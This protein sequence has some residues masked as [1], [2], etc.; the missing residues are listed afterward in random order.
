LTSTSCLEALKY[1]T[2]SSDSLFLGVESQ[3]IKNAILQLYS[4]NNLIIEVLPTRTKLIK[5][6][7]IEVSVPFPVIKYLERVFQKSWSE[8]KDV[9]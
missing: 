3:N 7:D 4:Q 2:I 1:K 8:L 9:I 5:I 6:N